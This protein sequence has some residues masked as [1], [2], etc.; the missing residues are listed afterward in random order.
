VKGQHAIIDGLRELKALHEAE[1][2][3]PLFAKFEDVHCS[4][5]GSTDIEPDND[6]LLCDS[7]GC[8]R[9]YHQKCQTP[10]VLTATIPVGDEP[11]FCEVCLAVFECLKAINSVF[12]ATYESVDGL[13]PELTSAE[14]QASTDASS[15]AQSGEESGAGTAPAEEDDEDEDDEDFVCSDEEEDEEEDGEDDASDKESGEA[16]EEGEDMAVEVPESAQDLRFLSTDDVIDP[17]KC[18]AGV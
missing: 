14:Q 10:I 12:G 6:I 2:Q 11:W 4:R 17:K 16:G 13:F 1:P 15:T 7:V 5:C 18:V 9:A 8:H 3:V